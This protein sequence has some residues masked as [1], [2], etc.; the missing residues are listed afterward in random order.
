MEPNI[1]SAL[2]QAGGAVAVAIAFIWYLDRRDKAQ[3]KKDSELQRFF[4]QMHE[5]DN[6]SVIRLAD[7][8]DTLV[9]N[10][11]SLTIK[12]DSHDE[13]ERQVFQNLDKP[14]ARQK[15]KQ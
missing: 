12:F 13:Y 14:V 8:I 15:A 5:E 7:V 2:V 3:G 4:Q 11:Q 6:K 1:I 9:K 10:V